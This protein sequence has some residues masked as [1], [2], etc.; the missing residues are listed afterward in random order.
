[1][2]TCHAYDQLGGGDPGGHAEEDL[3]SCVQVV[4]RATQGSDGVECRGA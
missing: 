1:M 4:E 3:V 2:R